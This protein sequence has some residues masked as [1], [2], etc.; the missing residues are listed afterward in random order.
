MEKG[1]LF[2]S[3]SPPGGRACTCSQ[4]PRALLAPISQVAAERH[5][6]STCHWGEKSRNYTLLIATELSYFLTVF[7]V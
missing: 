5:N 7:F 1:N 6:S 3:E 4:R 2:G